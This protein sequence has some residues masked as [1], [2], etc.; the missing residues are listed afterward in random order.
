M[1]NYLAITGIV[2]ICIFFSSCKKSDNGPVYFF[3]ANVDGNWVTYANAKFSITPNPSDSSIKDLQITAGTEQN[4]I[5]II[6]QSA[7]SYATGS[8][9]TT[10]SIPYRLSLS[11]FKDDGNYLKVFGTAGPGT[12]TQPYYIVTITYITPTEIRGTITGNYLYDIYDAE[13]IN[14]TEGEFVAVKTQ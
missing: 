11:L 1:K 3:K 12:G 7:V 8:F 9:N 2:I 4:N 14:V 13:T 6:M 10:D 5:S